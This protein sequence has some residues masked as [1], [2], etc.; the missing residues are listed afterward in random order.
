MK[1]Q[2]RLTF[3]SLVKGVGEFGDDF[4]ARLREEARYFEFQILKIATNR[5]EELAKIK[6]ISGLR[7]AEAKFRLLDCIKTKPTIFFSE[8][9]E[10]LEFRSQAMAFASC[11]T[12]NKPDMVKNEVGYNFKKTF[13]KP[14]EKFTG[15]KGNGHLC[16]GCPGKPH[17]SKLC[18]ALNKKCI[19]S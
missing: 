6:F 11:S 14:N 16:E 7:D 15:R 3:L 1:R 2:K 4:L 13:R 18:P 19:I 8:M 12:G 17:S 9:T 10:N 5:G